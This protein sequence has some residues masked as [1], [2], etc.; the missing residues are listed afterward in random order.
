MKNIKLIF[1]FAFLTLIIAL[2]G[3]GLS[4]WSTL[5]IGLI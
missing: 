4:F 5:L 2:A 1:G 3:F